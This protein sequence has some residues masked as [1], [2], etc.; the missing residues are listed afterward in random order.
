MPPVLIRDMSYTIWRPNYYT[1]RKNIRFATQITLRTLF[2]STAGL[3]LV[4]VLDIDR[5][6]KF[7]GKRHS[8]NW[9]CFRL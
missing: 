7:V 9:A 6:I 1:A 4:R 8:K 5:L 3:G 2:Y